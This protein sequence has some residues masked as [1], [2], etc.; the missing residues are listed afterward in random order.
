MKEFATGVASLGLTAIPAAL[1]NAGISYITDSLSLRFRERLTHHVHNI[2]LDQMIYYKALNES[3]RIGNAEQRITQDVEKFCTA[4]SS[5]YSTCLKPVVDV[6]L[7]TQKL[8]D[9][10][11]NAFRMW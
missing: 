10:S 11:V 6:V 5:L 2:Y 9:R 1:C 3:H 4:F 7:F 8:S